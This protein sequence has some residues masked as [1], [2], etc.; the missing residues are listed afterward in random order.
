MEDVLNV[1]ENAT[2]PKYFFG[3]WKI[4]YN[5]KITKKQQ[6]VKSMVVAPLAVT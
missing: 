4:T 1:F 2:L 5:K 3:K 6:K